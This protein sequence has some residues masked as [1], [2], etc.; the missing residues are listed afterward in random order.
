[1]RVDEPGNGSPVS[2]ENRAEG[3]AEAT[4]AAETSTPATS[5]QSA[6]AAAEGSQS[7]VQNTAVTVRVGS[8]GDGA[9]VEQTNVAGGPPTRRSTPPESGQSTVDESATAAA[10][11]DGVTNTNVSIRVFSPG[12]D[13]VVSQTNTAEAVAQTT[14][15]NGATAT[16]TQNGVQNTSVSVRVESDGTSGAVTQQSAASTKAGAPRSLGNRRRN[17]GCDDGKRARHR[18][19]DRGRRRPPPA[20]RS[21]RAPGLGVDVELGS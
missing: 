16:A 7:D 9:T 4:A 21:E 20:A 19:L 3:N 1:M 8:P 17:R 14:G 12:S 15:P 10:T 18:S 6:N 5:D 11:Q 13:G 2:Q